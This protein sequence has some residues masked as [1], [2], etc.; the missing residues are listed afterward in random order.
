MGRN[1]IKYGKERANNALSFASGLC[2]D[3]RLRDED[4]RVRG[5]P[6]I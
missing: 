2:T 1:T 5:N 6:K 4:P 3:P